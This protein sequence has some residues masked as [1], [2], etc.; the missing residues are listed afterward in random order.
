MV[1]HHPPVAVRTQTVLGH[2]VRVCAWNPASAHVRGLVRYSKTLH[3]I[4]GWASGQRR[5]R[6]A[7]NGGT[8]G[9]HYV[10]SGNVWALGRQI[11]TSA[12]NAPAVG[13]RRGRMYFG[14]E[15]ARL[16]GAVNIMNGLAYLVRDGKAIR[17][18]AEAPWTTPAQFGCG[19]RGSDGWYGCFRSCAVQFKN[20]RVALVE[21]S[22]ASMPVAARILK[23]MGAVTAITFDSGGAA[24]IDTP[25]HGGLF[26]STS[27][28]IWHRLLPDDMIVQV[29]R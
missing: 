24:G 18:H 11:R 5:V 22:L 26:G 17:T 19:P 9:R 27:G 25:H 16:H 23:S 20:G 10:P 21:V 29:T 12:P 2:H 8:Y 4:T 13:F 7:M 3:T 15:N 28:T 6:C 1:A 14:Y